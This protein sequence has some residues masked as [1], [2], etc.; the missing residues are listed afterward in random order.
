M[1]RGSKA[2]AAEEVKGP[3][4]VAEAVRAYVNAIQA[5]LQVGRLL[6]RFLPKVGRLLAEAVRASVPAVSALLQAAG[7]PGALLLAYTIPRMLPDT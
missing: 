2:V 4:P 3:P 7:Q 1:Q 6:N 5:L